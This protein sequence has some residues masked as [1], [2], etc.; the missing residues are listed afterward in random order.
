MAVNL[1]S[2]PAGSEP[3]ELSAPWRLLLLSDGSVT[4]HLQLLT[5]QETV[6]QCLEMRDI[7]EHHRGLPDDVED[8]PAPLVQRQVLLHAGSVSG[9][10]LVYAASWWN[11]STVDQYLKDKSQP[12]WVSLSRGHVE[13]Y[14]EV[15]QVYLGTSKELE[16]I[17]GEEGPFWGRHY[18]FWHHGTPLTLIF[19]VFSNSLEGYLGPKYKGAS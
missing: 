6:V 15:R 10:P 11:S 14:R 13:L 7:G 2:V 19:E 16:H 18:F 1:T 4:R 8:I 17:L 12:I 5:G 9:P 3:L